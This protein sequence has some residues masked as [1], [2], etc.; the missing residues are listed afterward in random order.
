MHRV[1]RFIL[2]IFLTTKK[3]LIM[4]FVL[5]AFLV[6]YS[7]TSKAESNL[8]S[9]KS[10]L[11]SNP[12]NLKMRYELAKNY[13]DKKQFQLA[14]DILIEKVETLNQ[15][16]LI[17]LVDCYK[18]LNDPVHELKFLEQLTTTYSKYAPGFVKLGDYY[19]RKSLEKNDPK[20]SMNTLSAY[21]TAIEIS[22]I[23]RPAYD[24]L[25]V[26][27]EK[28][29]NYYELR[30]L[31]GDMLK[32]FGKSPEVLSHLCRRY[33]LDSFFVNARKF[34]NEAI[35][36]DIQNPD[37]I[38]YLALVENNEG[39][40]QKAEALLKK[41]TSQFPRSEFA[42]ANYADFLIQ[43]KN[44]L[45]AENSLKLATSADK[46][47]FRAQLGLAKVSFELK[48]YESS[49]DAYKK[50]CQINPYLTYKYIKRA[51]D[52]LRHKRESKAEDSF[53]TAM[54]RCVTKGTETRSPASNKE[55][56]RSPFAMYSKNKLPEF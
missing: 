36:M 1:K 15:E 16:S 47:S 23:Y 33:T 38:V 25:L 54:G 10:Q 28:Y 27:Y 32:H 49:L 4:T 3:L 34:C 40:I 12:E 56:F 24:G 48:H 55:E 35:S 21:K 9:L 18:K 17:L 44:L 6:F 5:N 46:N 31:L 37:N 50:A 39:Q 51:T 41:V 7:E 52:L 11:I 2:M 13:F 14:A 19:F 26:A 30:I 53:S 20:T 45:A 22:P 42:H 8:E 29:K 43:Q